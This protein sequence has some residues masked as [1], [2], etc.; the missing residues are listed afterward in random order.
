MIRR[1]TYMTTTASPEAVRVLRRA[2]GLPGGW[3]IVR[4]VRDGRQ[5]A[6]HESRLA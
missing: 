6:M 2:S 5:V 4:F 1:S 3:W